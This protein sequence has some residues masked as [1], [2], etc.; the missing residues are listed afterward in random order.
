MAGTKL[1]FLLKSIDV[2]T[3]L[4]DDGLQLNGQKSYFYVKSKKGVLQLCKEQ[5]GALCNALCES[6]FAFNFNNLPCNIYVYEFCDLAILEIAFSS[7]SEITSFKLPAA[8]RSFVAANITNDKNYETTQLA[9][10]GNPSFKLDFAS[11]LK[12]A[13]NLSAFSLQSPGRISAYEGVKLVLIALFK[14][15]SADIT[16][17]LKHKND[18]SINALL[19]SLRQNVAIM[20]SFASLF[21]GHILDIFINALNACIKALSELSKKNY[22]CEYLQSQNI[23]KQKFAALE[24]ERSVLEDS[25]VLQVYELQIKLKEWAYVLNDAEFFYSSPLGKEEIKSSLA[26]LLSDQLQG[27][28]K[29]VNDANYDA[30]AQKIKEL[31]SLVSFFG[32]LYNANSFAK[33]AKKLAK[34]NSDFEHISKCRFLNKAFD[35]P[36][37]DGFK[38]ELNESVKK[39]LKNIDKRANK[40]CKS[41][42]KILELLKIYE[43]KGN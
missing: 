26:P 8:L 11:A 38:K 18:K 31:F 21:D 42:N 32:S 4:G 27:F 16:T 39:T 23:G 5:K 7:A 2:I 28:L 13:Q 19:N 12:Y 14:L 20:Q 1:R 29:L 3:R 41:S 6:K 9:L 25:C 34:I 15:L 10:F 33:F 24:R 43:N 30:L 37:M 35:G 17:F 22:L 36:Q 40:L